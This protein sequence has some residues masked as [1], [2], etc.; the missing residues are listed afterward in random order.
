MSSSHGPGARRA[1]RARHTL[2]GDIRRH[3]VTG[4]RQD[5]RARNVLVYLPPGYDRSGDRRYPALY[6]NDGQNVF[7]GATAFVPGEE[8]QLDETAGRLIDEG[9]IAPL[10]IVAVDHAGERRLDEFGPVRDRRR[11]AG[12]G[13]DDYGRVLVERIKPLVD[14]RY[15]TRPGREDT[16]LC[17]SSMGGLVTL[18]LGLTRPDAF[19]RLAV[20]SPSVW[21]GRRA[22]VR[23]VKALD[24]RPASR[25]W[26]DT[27][28]AEGVHA[29]SDVRALRD[30]MVEKGWRLGD[31]LAY[32]EVDGAPHSEAA[33]AARVDQ[34][35]EFLF[36]ALTPRGAGAPGPR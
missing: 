22:V 10:I 27:G 8:W 34:V 17:G 30:A 2:T 29:L 19:S 21:W 3:R 13:A 20:M 16:G 11:N 9:R 15:R 14:R 1:A 25:I 18:Y 5:G 4:T 24:G 36:P 6:V 28:T 31:D 7:D 32:T 26:L 35:L 12:G 23:Q 33:W